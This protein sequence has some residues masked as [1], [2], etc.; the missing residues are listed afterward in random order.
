MGH[1]RHTVPCRRGVLT[2]TA[3]I[4]SAAARTARGVKKGRDRWGKTKKFF[5]N[6]KPKTD[7]KKEKESPEFENE[8]RM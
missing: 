4:V 1:Q 8:N 2:K 5:F 6:P 3:V 7:P